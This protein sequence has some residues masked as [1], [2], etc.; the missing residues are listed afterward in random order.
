MWQCK[1]QHMVAKVVTN[2]RSVNC[3]PNLQPMQV[4]K[5]VAKTLNTLHNGPRLWKLELSLLDSAA[6]SSENATT[7]SLQTGKLPIPQCVRNKGEEV[8]K[9]LAENPQVSDQ[10]VLLDF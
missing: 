8:L 7:I 10:H 6:R 1:W 3:W 5:L 9:S 4:A 2:A